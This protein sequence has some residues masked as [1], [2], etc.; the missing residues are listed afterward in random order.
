MIPQLCGL[1][2]RD[3]CK[4]RPI[5]W[6]QLIQPV[7]LMVVDAV[8]NIS[9]IGL[10]IEAVQLGGFDDRHGPREGFRARVCARK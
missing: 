6:Q 7:N 4:R 3:G 8:E 9:K 1:T 10:R 2:G 5:P